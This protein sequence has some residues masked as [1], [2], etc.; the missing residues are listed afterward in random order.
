MAMLQLQIDDEGPVV[1]VMGQVIPTPGGTFLTLVRS[2]QCRRLSSR[3]SVD[4][5]KYPGELAS[6]PINGHRRALESERSRIL[7]PLCPCEQLSPRD[8][9]LNLAQGIVS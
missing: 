3:A 4:A 7:P 9:K 2:R 5:C 6:A 8:R 1:L